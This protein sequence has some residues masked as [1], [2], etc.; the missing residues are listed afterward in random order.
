MVLYAAVITPFAAAAGRWWKL[1]SGSA[2][3]AKLIAVHQWLGA[4]GAA[5]SDKGRA[6][7]LGCRPDLPVRDSMTSTMVT[8]P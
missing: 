5:L 8:E 3:P 1:T 4:L 2:L 6:V 7:R